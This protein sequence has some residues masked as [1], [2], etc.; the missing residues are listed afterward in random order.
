VNS[1]QVESFLT[2]LSRAGVQPDEIITD[3]SELYP[4]VL[5]R[6][7]PAAAH[8]L[9]LFH[10]TR[11]VTAAVIEVIQSVRKGLPTPPP[12]PQRRWGGPLYDHPP[13]DNPAGLEYQRWQLRRATRQAGIAQVHALAKQGLS[14]RSIA[15]QLGL[16]RRTVKT[17]LQLDPPAD[18][19]PELAENWR[20][21]TLPDVT[22][23][24]REQR[25]ARR[26][27]VRALARQGLSY[28]AIARQ[29]GIHRVTVKNWL[30]RDRLADQDVQPVVANESEEKTTP[31]VSADDTHLAIP[32]A[33]E[34]G[35]VNQLSTEEMDSSL[36]APPAPWVNWDQVREIREALRKHRFLLLRRPEHLDAEQ[37]AQV[38]ALLTSP[39]GLQL[40]V[41]R[42]FLEEWY[43]MWTDEQGHRRSLEEARARC[44]AW[45]SNPDYAAIPT[46]RRIQERMTDGH[47]ER[48][49]QFLRH[50]TWE[51]TNN[52]AERAGRAFRHRQAPHFNLRGQAAIEGALVV[53]ACQQKV[54][55]TAP[56]NRNVSR[57][58]RGRKQR[59]GASRT[60]V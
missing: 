30:E 32:A 11:R 28:S 29:V 52:G 12:Q 48:L 60:I 15:R 22:T 7:W 38:D 23:M 31:A 35:D 49:S 2:Q 14:Q 18:V 19:D 59:D 4:A 6:V 45:R 13:T 10:E 55:A 43:L 58:W 46:L 42:T 33:S 50:P 5:A 56:P 21:R 16:H 41:V 3:G 17:W 51:A 8:Q 25:E 44:E 9:C 26:A 27:Q 57:C 54:A 39:V 1:T 53:A 24:R 36:P 40:R 20:R 47:F 37:R 34:E